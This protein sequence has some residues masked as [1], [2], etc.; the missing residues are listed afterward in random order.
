[1]NLPVEEIVRIIRDR[2]PD[3]IAIYLFG[4]QAEGATHGESDLDL[5]V[6]LPYTTA[7]K[8]DLVEWIDLTQSI[9][10]CSE[11]DRVD[12]INLRRVDT[13]F[14]FQVVAKG[15]RI[16]CSDKSSADEFEILTIALYQQLEFERKEIIEEGI[17]SGR[18][19][20]V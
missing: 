12:L 11:I 15:N 3:T 14:R 1:M 17:R 19:H 13:V 9:E 16:F 8:V 20:H 6:L 4:S 5:A 18:F 2:Y 7:S 10:R